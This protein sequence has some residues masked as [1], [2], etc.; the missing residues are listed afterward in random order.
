MNVCAGEAVYK[1]TS[2]LPGSEE[3]VIIGSLSFKTFL[4]S[5]NALWVRSPADKA[6][7]SQ[8]RKRKEWEENQG[9]NPSSDAPSPCPPPATHGQPHFLFSPVARG[10]AGWADRKAFPVQEHFK[11]I[12]A[13]KS[14]SPTTGSGL[15]KPQEPPSG[16]LADSRLFQISLLLGSGAC[17]IPR[18]SL[19]HFYFFPFKQIHPHLPLGPASVWGRYPTGVKL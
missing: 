10:T 13:W 16:C 18:L 9:P 11:H 19:S 1:S 4:P 3:A 7:D 14:R 6:G 12:C 8:V 2:S 5:T 15:R 17:S